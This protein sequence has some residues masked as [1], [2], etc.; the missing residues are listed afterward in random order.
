LP[1]PSLL[2]LS[3]PL[4]LPF[5]LLLSLPSSSTLLQ[6]HPFVIVVVIMLLGSQSEELDQTTPQRHCPWHADGAPTLG[7]AAQGLVVL[8]QGHYVFD[9][10]CCH[11][12]AQ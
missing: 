5:P 8:T 11:L 10:I 6:Q 7:S 2:L 1:L 12:D 4:P 9:V 3:S